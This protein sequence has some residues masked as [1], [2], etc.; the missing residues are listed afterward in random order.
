MARIEKNILTMGMA[1]KIGQ[2][3]FRRRNGKTTAYI[4]KP[5]NPPSTPAMIQSQT[6]FRIAVK[7]AA[8]AM[9]NE[10]ELKKFEKLAKQ[11]KKESAYAAAISYFMKRE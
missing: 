11:M 6:R 5:H 8:A 9:K 1:G 10:T 7:L 4:R 2:V 3:V